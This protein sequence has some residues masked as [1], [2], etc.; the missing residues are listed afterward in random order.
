MLEPLRSLDE[1]RVVAPMLVLVAE[2]ER[3]VVADTLTVA[4]G[5]DAEGELRAPVALRGAR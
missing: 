5:Q 4:G 1:V 3:K 2:V